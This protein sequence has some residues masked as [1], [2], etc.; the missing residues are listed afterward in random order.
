MKKTQHYLQKLLLLLALLACLVPVAG[1]AAVH[2]IDGSCTG[3]VNASAGDTVIIAAN[4][5]SATQISIS[6][7]LVR[8]RQTASGQISG[9]YITSSGIASVVIDDL[10]IVAPTGQHG[11]A[12]TTGSTLYLEGTNRVT[13]TTGVHVASSNSLIIDSAET[14]NTSNPYYITN[15]AYSNGIPFGSLKGTLTAVGTGGADIG[16]ANGTPGTDGATPGTGVTGETGGILIVKGGTIMADRIAGGNGGRGGHAS[17]NATGGTGGGG[18]GGIQ[19]VLMGGSVMAE[20]IG[21]GNGGI[22]GNGDVSGNGGNGGNGG[23]APTV[24]SGFTSGI[25]LKGGV[26]GP[27]GA[28]LK[29]AGGRGGAVGT[30]GATGS[31]GTAGSAGADSNVLV[32]GASLHGAV[33]L[34][35]FNYIGTGA[36]TV[37]GHSQIPR[38][39]TLLDTDI[40]G[41]VHSALWIPSSGGS[42]ENPQVELKK[43]LYTESTQ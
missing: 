13:G 24:I 43:S 25:I 1:E 20:Q 3:M 30:P 10:N 18:G 36:V 39:S 40:A 15:A 33:A 35:G 31:S 41:G 29:L 22:G 5:A 19:F 4:P 2:T 42:H 14:L 16:G 37:T 7:G 6:G 17:T 23:A 12:L 26:L 27:I 9:V 38:L 32:L 8:I 21:G 28:D 34:S 11:I